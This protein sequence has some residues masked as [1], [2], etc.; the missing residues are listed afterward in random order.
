M[1]KTQQP[2]HQYTNVQAAIPRFKKE[3]T[4]ENGTI[5]TAVNVHMTDT[6]YPIQV[7]FPMSHKLMSFD[8]C[9]FVNAFWKVVLAL[10]AL[11][12]L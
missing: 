9:N 5:K 10:N 3:T 7:I 12:N 6:Q 1:H 2:P 11:I 8:N 4:N